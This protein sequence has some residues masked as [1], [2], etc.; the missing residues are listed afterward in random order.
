MPP[1]RLSALLLLPSP[2]PWRAR[3]LLLRCFTSVRRLPGASLLLAGGIAAALAAVMRLLMSGLLGGLLP[4]AT[5]AAGTAGL[6]LAL[7]LQPQLAAL[8]QVRGQGGRRAGDAQGWGAA[9][10]PRE[11]RGSTK[12]GERAGQPSPSESASGCPAAATAS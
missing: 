8:P 7:V 11:I 12:S 4:S 1:A 6:L 9:L 3:A 2:L 5:V 10:G